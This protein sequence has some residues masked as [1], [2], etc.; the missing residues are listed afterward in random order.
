MISA[1]NSYAT[2]KNGELGGEI[3]NKSL[4]PSKIF[5]GGNLEV[6][7]ILNDPINS[8]INYYKL[9]TFGV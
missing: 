1:V 6:L 4:F 5:L 8:E 9:Y 3:K 7:D 2:T